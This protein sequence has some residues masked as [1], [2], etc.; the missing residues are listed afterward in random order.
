MRIPTL[1]L[2]GEKS[3]SMAQRLDD[4]LETL[5]P[6]VEHLYIPD[7]SHDMHEGNAPAVNAAIV[8]FLSRFEAG[9]QS[10]SF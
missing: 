1:L 2:T 9:H 7:A 6:N 5:R 4:L 3:P 10:H 8:D